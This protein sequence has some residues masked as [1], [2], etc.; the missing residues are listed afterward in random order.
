MIPA[1]RLFVG[2]LPD[3]V[4][5]NELREAF[6]AFGEITGLDIKTKSA[7]ENHKKPFAF[8]TLSASNYD[9]ESCIK[10]FTYENFNGT[11]LYVTKARESFLERLQRERELAQRKEAEKNEP[12]STDVIPKP[13][14]INLNSHK[15][16]FDS[17][18]AVNENGFEKKPRKKEKE[19]KEII[20]ETNV[21]DTFHDKASSKDGLKIPEIDDKKQ[22]SDKKRL[23]SM[24]KKRQEFNQK[25]MI[26]KSG[27]I[28]IDKVPNKK[29]IF[30]DDDDERVTTQE[31]QNGLPVNQTENVKNNVRNKK[32]KTLFDEDDDSDN[33][34]NF[35]IK[36]QFEGKKGQKVLDMQSRYK[37]DKRF[38]LDERFVEDDKSD[39]EPNIVENN[40]EDVEL[41][42][43]DEKYKQLNILQDVLGVPIKVKQP[44][45]PTKQTKSKIGM[46]RFDPTQPEHAKFLAPVAT[47]QE[48]P[49]KSKKKKSKENAEE[50][51]VQEEPKEIEKVEVSK[52]QFYKVSDTL[53]EAMAQPG[54]FS[55][56]S[57]FG[58]EDVAEDDEETLQQIIEHEIPQSTKQ[59]K[60]RNPL[61]PGEKNP[62]VYDS[63]DSENEEETKVEKEVA[64]QITETKPVWREK[65]FFSESD[66]RLK[67]GL[68]F[69]TQNNQ[70][71][72]HKD[73]RELK[74]V[75]KKRVYNKERKSQMFQKKI[76]GRRKT[77]KKNFRKKS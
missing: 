71:K 73:R 30:S 34:V 69:F 15:R 53:K 10:H 4:N 52:E 2:N 66:D 3:R 45:D 25:K 74:S 54:S 8:V 24:K 6:S 77:V 28:G 55:L 35:E 44:Q 27:L 50:Q 32:S 46:L 23:E 75:M 38:V 1:T 60:V 48:Q 47:K 41:G 62:F 9:I 40:D 18:H 59:K 5:A 58:K 70:G 49:K 33:E 51:P 37:A 21:G 39:E 14:N 20:S 36:K 72:A 57:L 61:D 65:L 7:V 29:V 43:V 11:K 56:R 22:N 13:L 68:L 63:S 76:G 42:Q 67:E 17:T 64:P 16:K 26:I 19:H 12:S 31:S